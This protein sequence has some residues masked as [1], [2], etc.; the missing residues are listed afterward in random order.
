LRSISLPS[1]GIEDCERFED[2]E[3]DLISSESAKEGILEDEGQGI[4]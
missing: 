4:K 2:D 1:V 3:R